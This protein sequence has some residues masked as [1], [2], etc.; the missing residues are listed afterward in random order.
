MVE[1]AELMID[2]LEA[3]GYRKCSVAPL[4]RPADYLYQKRVT[5][6]S[7][8]CYFLNAWG[9]DHE[10]R[11]AGAGCGWELEVSCET[12]ADQ[13]IRLR[14]GYKTAQLATSEQLLDKLW[15][16]TGAIAYDN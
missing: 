5:A 3:A 16:A 9:Y 14:V 12:P 13:H 6:G 11:Q 2:V 7:S 10:Q 1:Q 8:T 4:F 15:Q